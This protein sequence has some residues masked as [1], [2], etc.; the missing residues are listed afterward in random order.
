MF[1]KY[2]QKLELPKILEILEQY[3]ISTIGK[4]LTKELN[5]SNNILE[6]KHLLSETTQARNLIDNLGNAPISDIQDFDK[7]SIQLD[8][9]VALSCQ[10]LLVVARLLKTSRALKNYFDA[11]EDKSKYD[12]IESYFQSLYTNLDLEN[13]IFRSILDENTISDDASSTL[14]SLRR[15]RRS[16]E[17]QI[18]ENLNKYI[19]SSTYSKYIMEPII[20]IR[21]DRY[22]IPVK[23][24]YK[25]Q[26]K[27]FI[28]DMSYSGSTV[29]IEPISIFETN[30]EIHNLQLEENIEIERI[31]KELS[32]SIFPIKS[33]LVTSFQSIG[34]I[35]L[36]FA[37][38][39]FS[40]EYN[41][42]E[43]AINEDKIIT[44]KQARHPLIDKKSVV[45]IDIE[46]GKNYTALII[47][48]PNTGR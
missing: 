12:N 15:K 40:F 30:N 31:L 34:N 29:F 45:P 27:G 2:T 10:G 23:I 42:I 28:H 18:K 41:C 3:C 9:N 19:H 47:T 25:D 46:I 36:I 20:T 8:S 16:L 22:V 6:V 48:G 11:V 14:K 44:L 26:I 37:R 7:I 43:P 38:A 21:N 24:E 4:S 1:E 13:K 39:K 32:V 35:D 17:S 5:P 33:N